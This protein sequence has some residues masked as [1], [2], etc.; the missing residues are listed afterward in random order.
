MDLSTH[1]PSPLIFGKSPEHY[2]ALLS[3]PFRMKLI[4]METLRGTIE[5]PEGPRYVVIGFTHNQAVE[6]EFRNF[7]PGDTFLGLPVPM[8]TTKFR[9]ALKKQGIPTQNDEGSI[10]L[11][12]HGVSFYSYE[13]EIASICWNVKKSSPPAE[14]FE[15]EQVS[16]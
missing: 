2:E 10:L 3:D 16:R 6:F 8:R 1:P 5:F 4:T 14:N 7:E 12:A 13:G 11:P 9:N 15:N